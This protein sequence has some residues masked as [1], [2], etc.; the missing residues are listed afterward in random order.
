M[1]EAISENLARPLGEFGTEGHE[2]ED[3]G[4][5]SFRVL[6]GYLTH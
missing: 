4:G 6:D 1:V 5:D 3:S 2:K